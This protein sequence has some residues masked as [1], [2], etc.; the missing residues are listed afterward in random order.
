MVGVATSYANPDTDGVAGCVALVGL[1]GS[2][3]FPGTLSVV[4]DGAINGETKELFSFAGVALPPTTPPETYDGIALVDTHHPRQLPAWVRPVQVRAVID[5]H[6][7]GDPA[8]FPNAHIDNQAVGA[9]CTLIA[10]R[11]VAS[12]AALQVPVAVLLQGGILSNTLEFVAPST[13]GRDRAAINRLDVLTGCGDELAALLRA[14]RARF[15][16]GPTEAIIA[17]DIKTFD[18]RGLQ[19]GLSQLEAPGASTIARRSDFWPAYHRVRSTRGLDVLVVNLADLAASAS[20]LAVSDPAWQAR[21][22]K[23]HGISFDAGVG[24]T[25]EVFLRKTHLV[26]MLIGE[27]L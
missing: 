10:E 12:G 6:P 23:R 4:L 17:A 8:A 27:G 24:W 21:L 15:V 1:A 25:G 18:H 14:A 20:V 7:G 9:A 16:E 2:L 22:A 11:Y 26:P 5:H 19:L 3:G 13:T